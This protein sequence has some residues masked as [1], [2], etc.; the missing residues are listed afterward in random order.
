MVPEVGSGQ[1]MLSGY[2]PVVHQ[3][4]QIQNERRAENCQAF[5][6]ID[7][8]AQMHDNSMRQ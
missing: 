1:G 4:K 3:P 6:P 2:A 7:K 8:A 5:I